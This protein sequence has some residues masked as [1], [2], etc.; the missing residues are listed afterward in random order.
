[1]NDLC[2]YLKMDPCFRQF[3]HKDVTFSMMYAFSE[4]Y[5]AAH[6]P[7]RGGPHEGVPRGEDARRRRRQLAG[8]RGFYAYLLAHPGKKLL[9]MGTE[10]GQWHEWAFQGQL[11][12]Y[13]LDDPQCRGTHEVHP[14]AEPAFITSRNRRLW[15]K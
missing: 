2:H 6:V 4:N 14:G 1:M 11:D 8:V 7:R 10:M 13:L 3:H 15:E 12:W 9:F 5:G